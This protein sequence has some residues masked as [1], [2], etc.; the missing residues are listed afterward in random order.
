MIT[1]KNSENSEPRVDLEWGICRWRDY[2][3]LENPEFIHFMCI[4]EH[5]KKIKHN[6]KEDNY[7]K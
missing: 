6:R 1:I 5:T 4:T 2:G 3:D 7:A